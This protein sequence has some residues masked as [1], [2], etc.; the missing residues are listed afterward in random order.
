M[1]RRVFTGIVERGKTREFLDA[2]RTSSTHQTERGIR[3]RT[4]VWGAMTGQT[5]GVMIAS[6]FDTLDELERFEDLSSQDASFAQI[7]RAVRTQMVFELSAVSILRLAY[8][9]EGL[10][11]SEEA[12][13]PHKF[14]RI[15]SGTVLPGRRREFV[16]SVSEALDYQ[17]HRGIDAV[18][19]VW[20]N[21]TGS[22]NSVAVVG[23]F[24]SLAELEA[25]DEMAQ[26][27]AGFA[28]LRQATRE[29]MVFPASHVD[30]MRN[31]L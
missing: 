7:R 5:N 17:K 2:L 10:I 13:A 12:T 16:L 31:L 4:T 26:Q 30:L 19:S 6:D 8:H 18:T 15:M 27:D 22:T 28:K 29:A 23:E 24:D 11:S 3:A 1:Y 14:M 20:S 9:S 25:F 21:V